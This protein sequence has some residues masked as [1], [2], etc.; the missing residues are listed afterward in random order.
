M[1]APRRDEI[2]DAV[3]AYDAANPLTPLPRNAARLLAA[4]FPAGDVCHRS[5]EDIAAEGFSRR[6]LPATLGRLHKAGFISRQP[7]SG[8]DTHQLHLPPVRR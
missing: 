5:L 7:G 1:S 6:S 8:A 4:M 3:A 2:A